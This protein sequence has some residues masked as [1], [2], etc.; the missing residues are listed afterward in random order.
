MVR[1]DD[2]PLNEYLGRQTDG[3]TKFYVK[4]DAKAICKAAQ[5]YKGAF[6]MIVGST[7]D[8]ILTG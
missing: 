6:V 4:G 3:F 5:K 7:E 1:S 2:A 8:V